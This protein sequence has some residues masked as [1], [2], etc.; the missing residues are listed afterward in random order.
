[1]RPV[2]RNLILSI[3]FATGLA[4]ALSPSAVASPDGEALAADRSFTS[5]INQTHQGKRRQ[6]TGPGVYLD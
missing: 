3:L 4:F 6:T 1:M 2:R 5:A